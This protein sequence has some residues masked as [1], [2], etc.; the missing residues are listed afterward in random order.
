[1]KSHAILMVDEDRDKI[2]R[3]KESIAKINS[4]CTFKETGN[5][6]SALEIIK[7]ESPGLVILDL[8]VPGVD[9][10]RLLTELVELNIWV[11]V[12]V[13]TGTDIDEKDTVFTEYGVAGFIAKPFFPID[14]ARR[15][16]EIIINRS[17]KDII[18]NFSLPSIL[19]L[20]DME[21][22]TGIL[23]VEIDGRGGRLFFKN[24]KVMDIRVKGLST[25]DA[26]DKFIHSFYDD[27]EISIEY[28]EHYKGKKV[29]MSLI[30][31]VIEASRIKD[32]KREK[33]NGNVLFDLEELTAANT[34]KAPEKEP[35]KNADL[36]PLTKLLNSFK[37][38]NGF[39][40]T[41][42]LGDV[43][44]VSP[45]GENDDVLNLSIYLWTIGGMM[46]DTFKLGE[47]GGLMCHFKDGRRLI[48]KYNDYIII[49]ELAKMTK[50]S[51]FKEKLDLRLNLLASRS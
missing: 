41:G 4:D 19:Q 37:E 20:I 28:I 33:S 35:K 34:S 10:R 47:A 39:I 48:K 24:G 2:H 16:D 25:E 45:G 6:Q 5:S 17:K 12:L 26:M 43:L 1:M 14:L 9:V 31:M 11:P 7:K 8:D 32:E 44:S 46:G 18:K 42:V 40:V 51:A 36:P 21:K 29:S 38:L 22:R 27:R 13:A 49:L 30:Q 50:Y 23:T 3:L 15:I